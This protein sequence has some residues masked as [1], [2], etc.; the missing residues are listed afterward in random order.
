MQVTSREYKVI[1]DSALFTDPETA[2][3]VIQEDTG[4]LAG[5][6]NVE[7]VGRFEAS[8][9]KERT[10]LFL[11]TPDFTLRWNG[12]LLRKR[13]KKKND[14]VEYTLKSR[15]EDRYIAAGAD[16]R[17]GPDLEFDSKF[18]EDI[19]VPFVSRF[20]HSTTVSSGN[21][22]AF[23]GDSY[24]QTLAAAAELFPGLLAARRDGMPCSPKTAILPV[25]GI[26]VFERVYSG[27]V[28]HLP[29]IDSHSPSAKATVAVIVWTKGPQ[30]RVLTAEFSFRYEEENEVFEPEVARAARRFFTGLQQLDWTRPEGPTKTQYLYGSR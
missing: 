13:V 21:G 16:H 2:L 3:S 10:V 27:P 20:S 28:I 22:V 18:E 5:E 12:L 26:P 30:G 19:G 14:K 4:G 9:P 7:V 23:T 29:K 15:N 8:D 24:P 6:V 17:T 11:D 1:I 25:N